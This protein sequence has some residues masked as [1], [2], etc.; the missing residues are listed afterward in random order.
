MQVETAT[1]TKVLPH[2]DR[3]EPNPSIAD[4]PTVP[5]HHECG[6]MLPPA[7]PPGPAPPGS[8]PPAHVPTP[9]EAD[10][11]LRCRRGVS[12]DREYGNTVRLL[13]VLD[14]L[15]IGGDEVAPRRL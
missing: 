1:G 6:L 13:M 4:L 11:P 5:L 9:R 14:V 15:S 2:L 12:A 8:E 7:R 3:R 10:K